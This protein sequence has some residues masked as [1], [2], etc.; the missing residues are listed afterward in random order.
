LTAIID[1]ASQ[2]SETDET[3]NQI[4]RLIT[5]LP[6]ASDKQPPVVDSFVVNQGS[7]TTDNQTVT[8]DS[9]AHDQPDGSDLG[10]MMYVEMHW[11]GGVQ[12]WVPVQFTT[13]L[14]YGEVHTWKLH[15]NPGMRYLQAW[16]ADRAGNISAA[17]AKTLINYVPG[18]DRL[19]AGETR[20]LRV[21]A[22][23][24][25]CLYV[26][27]NPVWGDADIYVWPPGFEAEH[28]YWYSILGPGQSDVVEF[29]VPVTGQYQIEVDG[30]TETE[31]GLDVVIA[32]NCERVESG[33]STTP[34]LA[35]VLRSKP[36]VEMSSEPANALALPEQTFTF[37]RTFLPTISR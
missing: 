4:T 10:S 27:A 9:I 28:S 30:V 17:P 37:L 5:V 1:P 24:G 3:N 15:P 33:E 6:S 14:P 16:V 19:F 21:Y 26:A 32:K 35:K 18:T 23:A 13:W 2:V 31:F 7:L 8:L 22:Q 11:S 20:V 12:T 34:L 36:F 25:Q 29:I